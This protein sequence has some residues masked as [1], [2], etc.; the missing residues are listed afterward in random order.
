MNGQ[1]F[2][3]RPR[4]A[5]HSGSASYA[6]DPVTGRVVYQATI[7]VGFWPF[8]QT[9][10][11]GPATYVLV[12]S[13][14]LKSSNW[15]TVGQKVTIGDATFTIVALSGNKLARVTI[16]IRGQPDVAISASVD[17]HGETVEIMKALV[18]YPGGILGSLTIE[19][20]E[21]RPGV[22]CKTSTE[23]VRWK[24][25]LLGLDWDF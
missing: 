18:T 1:N 24:Q 25:W 2:I 12:H 21:V 13:D 3:I 19:L 6:V 7:V 11:V 20:D 5:V 17:L 15:R 10:A 9:R 16:T 14:L 23:S 22:V 8:F 4:G